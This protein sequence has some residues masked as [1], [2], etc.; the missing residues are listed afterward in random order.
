MSILKKEWDIYFAIALII[1]AFFELYQ[2]LIFKVEFYTANNAPNNTSLVSKNYTIGYLTQFGFIGDTEATKRQCLASQKNGWNCYIFHYSKGTA[3][4]TVGARYLYYVISILNYFFKPDFLIHTQP[5]NFVIA[6]T[7]IPNYV[8]S[9]Y[10][11]A[12]IFKNS[13]NQLLDSPMFWKNVGN[14]DGYISYNPNY[15]WI[16]KINLKSI[17]ISGVPSNFKTFI[18]HTY[19]TTLATQYNQPKYQKLF[20]CGH[21]WDPLRN[22]SHYKSIIQTLAKENIIE[23][24]GHENSW[25]FIA[26]SYKGYL[27]NDGISIIKKI[28]ELG[29]ALIFHS[30]FHLKAGIPTGKIFEAA[31]AGALIISDNHSFVKK[32]FGDCILYVDP[33][34]PVKEV[35]DKIKEYVKWAKE[36]HQLAAKKSRCSH[37]IFIQKFALENEIL[38]IGKMHE[39]V[40]N[41]KLNQKL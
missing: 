20:Y 10:D 39:E 22:S 23:V 3:M 4:S 34:K 17:T 24:Y 15:D 9:T 27:P 30:S 31:A 1:L 32:E 14:Y 16:N 19:A 5:T 18:T 7:N 13:D 28:Q 26:N 41:E 29:I 36:N 33:T 12:K 2:Y 11:L 6:P 38:K 21:N 40:I 25:E 35:V 37:N 8:V